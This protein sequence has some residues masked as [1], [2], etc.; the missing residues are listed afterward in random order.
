MKNGLLNSLGL[1][2]ETFS[3]NFTPML[4]ILIIAITIIT[5]KF[6]NELYVMVLWSV[7]FLLEL[8]IIF[9][10]NRNL[11]ILL[12][13]GVM[14]ISI[15]A[16]YAFIGI[17]SA[18]LGYCIHSPLMF[19]APV[20]ALMVIEKCN[21]EQQIRFIFHFLALAIAINIADNI[22]LTYQ[23]GLEGI[24]YSK[25]SGM[26]EDEGLT[27]LNL[28]GSG[29]VNLAVFYS[30]IMFMAFLKIKNKKEKLLFLIYVGISTYFIT[31]C[32]LKASAIILMLLSMVLMY[33][34]VK[35]EERVGIALSMTII[36]GGLIFLFRDV[37]INFFI[38]IIDSNRV[39]SRLSA[40]TTEADL[41]D[42]GSFSSRSELWQVSLQSWLSS[43]K[44]FL[45]GI[46]DHDWKKFITTADSGIGN[47]SDFFDVCARY[48]I[49]GALILYSSIKIYYDYL[50]K[51]FGA[52]FRYEIITIIILLL[53]IGFTKRFITGQ[54]AVAIFIL[55]PLALRYCY[56][57]NT[58]QT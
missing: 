45:F 11:G 41:E 30:C 26:M 42:S 15:C 16:I 50:Q 5:P 8:D 51:R 13:L 10:S 24:V 3:S 9:R 37:I 47:H 56:N 23:I 17:S 1:S 36:C 4:A 2:R 43:I 18:S 7:F 29:F 12:T 57:K 34:S 44:S 52:F 32:S 58:I 6:F 35:S 39:T 49:L 40:L 46:G 22:R 31:F 14:F 20:L 25:L 28:G 19:F 53:A 48:G 27:G 55:F 54:Q 33:V 21:N 38:D